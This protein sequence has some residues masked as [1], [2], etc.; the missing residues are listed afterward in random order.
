MKGFTR[1]H[2]SKQK[3]FYESGQLAELRPDEPE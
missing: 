1:F 3:Y 2:T